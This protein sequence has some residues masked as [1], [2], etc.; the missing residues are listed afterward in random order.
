[1]LQKLQSTCLMAALALTLLAI[2]AGAQQN[3]KRLILKDG[4]FQP[5]TK[6]EV[7]GNRV[8]YYSAE[9]YDWEE[10]P[11]DLV[12]WPATDKY[13]QEQDERR[14]ETAAEA[15]KEEKADLEAEAALSPEVA[16]GLRLP[17]QGGIFLQDLFRGRVELAELTQNGGEL[18][19]DTTKNILRAAINPIGISTKQT[20]VLKGPRAKVQSHQVQPSIYINLGDE[21]VA[22]PEPE[23]KSKD[24]AS[25]SSLNQPFERYRIVRLQKKDD[26]RVVGSLTIRV[27]GNVSQKQDWVPAS[28][29]PVGR[30]IKITPLK[31]LE[32]GEYAVAEMLDEKEVNLYVWDFGVDPDAPAN[33]GSWT[34]EEPAEPGKDK[35]K[36]L[37]KK[38]K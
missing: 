26:R 21:G 3:P 32:P 12:D 23:K 17:A 9:R 6:W 38:P 16:P 25:A 31:R 37:E 36:E 2:P 11:K 30:W 13:N 20:I 34:P 24:Q 1:M 8:R 15:V 4:S 29:T 10:L 19:K 18:N 5:V 14:T 7:Q 33:P 27:T 35:P 28:N 22:A